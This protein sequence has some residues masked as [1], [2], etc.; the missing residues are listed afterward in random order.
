MSTQPTMPTNVRVHEVLLTDAKRTWGLKES[1]CAEDDHFDIN[2]IVSFF[3][4]KEELVA[5]VM[6]RGRNGALA[7][8]R[9]GAVPMRAAFLVAHFDA[10]I[11][12]APINPSTGREWG[13]GEMQ[14]ACDT[15]DACATGLLSDCIVSQAAFPDGHVEMLTRRYGGHEKAGNLHWDEPEHAVEDGDRFRCQGVIA[16]G[17]RAALVDKNNLTSVFA[18]TAADNGLDDETAYW[19]QVCA[20]I[21]CMIGTGAVGA[22]M[23]NPPSKAAQDLVERSLTPESIEEW[24]TEPM[25]SMLRAIGARFGIE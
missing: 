25:G 2:P 21:K 11:T 8:A 9:I 22:M 16:D 14:A 5:T 20:A 13:P 17:L 18:K 15:E 1:G 19:H 12:N 6:C 10:H 23:L 7:A 24:L 4:D 3:D